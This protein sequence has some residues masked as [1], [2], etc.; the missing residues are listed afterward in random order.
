MAL[1]GISTIDSYGGALVN[2]S[3]IGDPTTDQDAPAFNQMKVD[4]ASMTNTAC[5]AWVRFVTSA[6]TPTLAVTNNGQA[7]WG[8]APG[9][10][11][12]PSRVTGGQFRLTFPAST[13]DALGATTTTNLV[14][15]RADSEGTATLTSARAAVSG[16]NTVDIFTFNAAGTNGDIAGTTVLVLVG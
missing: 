13:T 14:W 12:V 6:T 2:K 11:A 15:A 16:A 9:V 10:R 4:C 8:N 3:P 5:R 1:P 7:V